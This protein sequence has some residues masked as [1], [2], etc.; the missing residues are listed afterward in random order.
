MD[1]AIIGALGTLGHN[2]CIALANFN[3][4]RLHKFDLRYDKSNGCF[5]DI[6]DLKSLQDKFK[7]ID[8]IIHL[9]AV[10]RVAW[11]EQ[12]PQLAQEVNVNG[13]ANIINACLGLKNKPWIIYASSRE[14]YG[15]CHTS[16]PIT[17][18]DQTRPYNIY[19]KTKLDSEKL[20]IEA[21][22]KGLPVCI[23]RFANIYGSMYDHKDRVIPAFCK[24]SLKDEEILV[25]GAESMIDFIHIIDAT[26]A[27]VKIIKL[28]K[29][30]TFLG[31]KIL[32]ICTSEVISLLELARLIIKYSKSKSQIKILPK[33]PSSV[34]SFSASNDLAFNTLSWKPRIKLQEG[35]NNFLND[36]SKADK[37]SSIKENIAE[38]FLLD[39]SFKS[40]SWLPAEI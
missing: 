32:N 25:K 12:I 29:K 6:R 34:S 5:L 4:I 18:L 2:L 28:V 39:E 36:L 24:A 3:D 30:S 38:G 33:E 22:N 23:M 26:V 8:G 37:S 35:I 19:G 10:S 13:T 14:V 20:L 7:N 15:N 1:I 11:A 17:E 16:A 31:C 27:I 40:Y 9:A 21:S